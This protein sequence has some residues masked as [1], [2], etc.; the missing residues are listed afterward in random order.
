V[1]QHAERPIGRESP[2]DACELSLS[3]P[4]IAIEKRDDFAAASW[5][6]G[7]ESGSLASVLLSDQADARFEAADDFRCTVGRAVVHHHDFKLLLRKILFQNT[8]QSLF[9]E[10]LVVVGVNQNAQK[11]VWE[12][13]RS[14]PGSRADPQSI[15]RVAGQ[16]VQVRQNLPWP[17]YLGKRDAGQ[18][19]AGG[20]FRLPIAP[21][22]FADS[23]SA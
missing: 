20:I 7:V 13:F 5:N 8:A 10:A 22:R 14:G 15:N 1:A 6:T 3:P 23:D 12:V 21:A 4:V 19:K 18:R 2:R 16:A 17:S 9:N 11:H